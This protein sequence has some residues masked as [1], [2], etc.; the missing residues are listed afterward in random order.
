MIIRLQIQ[1]KNGKVIQDDEL[2]VEEGD[3]LLCQANKLMSQDAYA[4]LGKNLREG[5]K[6]AS[7]R[8]NNGEIVSILYDHNINFKILKINQE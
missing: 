8:A 1:D 7:G 6:Y 4:R 3:I 2:V 5:F